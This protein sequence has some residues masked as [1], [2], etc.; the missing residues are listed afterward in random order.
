MITVLIADDEALIRSSI[1]Y[2]LEESSFKV[3]I[4]GEAENGEEALNMYRNLLPDVVIT[5][6]KMPALSG[7]EL[8]EEV[9]KTDRTT[10]FIVVS[11]YAEF[12]YA[13]QAMKSGV[14]HYVLKP[15]KASHIMEALKHCALFL[16]SKYPEALPEAR[17][18][19]QYIETH[20]ASPLSLDS[21]AK[22]FSFSPKYVSCLI[23]S[24]VG[25]SFTDYIIAL[26]MKEAAGLLTKTTQSVK[27]VA[28]TVGYEDPH[29]FHR[30]FKKK[31]GKTPEQ[32]RREV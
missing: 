17:Q 5:D 9:R 3:F 4:T 1:R 30:L 19:L 6:V 29:Y 28:G 27:S 2:M 18:L 14:S 26:R 8:I 23:K 12:E 32:F 7:L 15:I 21:L 20:F 16:E 10:Q 22:R 13:Q 11:G 31:T 24:K 25:L